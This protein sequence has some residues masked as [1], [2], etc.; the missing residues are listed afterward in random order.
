MRDTCDTG[1]SA[2]WRTTAEEEEA[3]EEFCSLY[4]SATSPRAV[5]PTIHPLVSLL[6]SGPRFEGPYQCPTDTEQGVAS[7]QNTSPPGAEIETP[8]NLA[9]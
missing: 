6:P 2:I 9:P 8:K 7:V 5:P 3:E 1:C 4:I